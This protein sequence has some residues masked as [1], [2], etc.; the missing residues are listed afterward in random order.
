MQTR[1]IVGLAV[2]SCALIGCK[3][4][5]PAATAA[6]PSAETPATPQQVVIHARDFAFDAPDTI[7]SG[8]TTIKLMNEGPDLHHVQLVR[9]EDGHTF[10][11]L[12]AAMA[13]PGP[14]PAWAVDVG[15]PNTPVPGGESSATVD[16]QPGNHVM[17]CFIPAP[18]G[19]MHVMK[20][21]SRPITVIPATA[22][23]AMPVAQVEMTLSDYTFTTNVPLTAGV[24]VVN[25]TNGA[26]QAHEV[27][28]VKLEPGKTVE[29]VVR[30]IEKPEG[31]PPGAPIG[32]TT[33]IRTGGT[34]QITL[35]L[36]AGGDYAF[37]CFIPD[38]KDG[39]P[40]V[41]HGMS[42]QFKVS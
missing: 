20:G 31:P 3:P 5:A 41:M 14:P 19:Q 13:N 6:E 11:E 22:S 4:D 2:V 17:I 33:A 15:G 24:Q 18:D 39:K 1:T 34:N 37:I 30:F 10:E 42:K 8:V 25:V 35:D 21:M 36:A 23:A 27:L 9:L 7:A 40:H 32:G 16:L 26:A 28:V 12:M 29:D 38:A